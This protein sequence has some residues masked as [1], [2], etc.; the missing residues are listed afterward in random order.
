MSDQVQACISFCLQIMDAIDH[1]LFML[2]STP[3]AC[4]PRA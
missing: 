4:Q 2:P 3:S 1:V